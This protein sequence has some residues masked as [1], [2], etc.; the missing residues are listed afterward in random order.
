[1][2]IL[3]IILTVFVLQSYSQTID[4]ISENKI[5]AGLNFSPD[6]SYRF[7]IADKDNPYYQSIA[8]RRDSLEIP[9]FGFTTGISILFE[10]NNRIMIDAG[11]QYANKGE[12]TKS[13]NIVIQDS[14]S[15]I[16]PETISA[17]FNYYY[18]DIPIK[19]NY[20][21]KKTNP[22]LFISGGISGNIFL[23]QKT[24]IKY[25][26][27]GQKE[28]FDGIKNYSYD[29][30][31]SGLAGLG[32]DFEI[33]EKMNLRIEPTFRC[34]LFQMGDNVAKQYLYSIGT[35]FGIYYIF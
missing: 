10:V 4:S 32:V 9:K 20:Y 35:N 26:N 19:V 25:M 12:K 31:F 13:Y 14:D 27:S 30:N 23:N 17:T 15:I 29:I 1:M 22:K 28:K 3:T 33:F 34:S 8:K 7:L 16:A 18:L 24:T 6:Y 2:R 5:Y 11:I 21:F